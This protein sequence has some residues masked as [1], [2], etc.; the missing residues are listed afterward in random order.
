MLY[1]SGII[2]AT[3]MVWDRRAV[4][5]VY[6][7]SYVEILELVTGLLLVQVSSV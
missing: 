7:I 2:S 3:G 6:L 4:P 1:W 5:S